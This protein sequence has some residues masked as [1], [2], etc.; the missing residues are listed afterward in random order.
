MI[1]WDLIKFREEKRIGSVCLSRVKALLVMLELN[2]LYTAIFGYKFM[3][4]IRLAMLCMNS[5]I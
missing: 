1:H 2:T 5:I 4:K 3:R